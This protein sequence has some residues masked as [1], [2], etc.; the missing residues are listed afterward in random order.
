MNSLVPNWF[1]S[2]NSYPLIFSSTNSYPLIGEGAKRCLVAPCE[3]H[4]LF[5]AGT[6][7]V[8]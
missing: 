4:L 1:S 2:T 5:P 6:L 3:C 7:H 8:G